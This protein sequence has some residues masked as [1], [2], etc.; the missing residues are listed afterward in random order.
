MNQILKPEK[1]IFENKNNKNNKINIFFKKKIYKLLFYLS[2]LIA[3]YFLSIS[4]IRIIK[5]NKS[6]EISSKLKSNYQ[7]STLYPNDENYS[8]EKINIDYKEPFVIG[9]VK[10]DKI[11]LNY[12]ILSESSKDFLDISICRFAGPMPN[13]SRKSLYCRS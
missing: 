5:I 2:C 9:I 1:N 3:F 11:N 10:I 7:I 4:F 12:P 6:N 13:E 8:A